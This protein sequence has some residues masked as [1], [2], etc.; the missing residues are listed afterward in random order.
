MEEVNILTS[1][2][3]NS[4]INICSDARSRNKRVVLLRLQD[5]IIKMMKVMDVCDHFIFVE[6]IEEGQMKIRHYT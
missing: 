4:L 6:S 5:D 3:L 2:G 1:S